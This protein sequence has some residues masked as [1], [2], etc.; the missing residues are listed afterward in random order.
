[1]TS[2]S[3]QIAID[4][5]EVTNYLKSKDNFAS[6]Q[7]SGDYMLVTN[8]IL[9]LEFEEEGENKANKTPGFEL[10]IGIVSIFFAYVAGKR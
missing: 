9:V 1:M 10:L 5:R 6:I 4:E 3:V 8:A 7:D 2:E